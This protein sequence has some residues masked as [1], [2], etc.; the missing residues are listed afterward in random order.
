MNDAFQVMVVTNAI[1][2]IRQ[3][4]KLR[5]PEDVE[6]KIRYV[7]V[8]RSQLSYHLKCTVLIYITI[9]RISLHFQTGEAPEPEAAI[10]DPRGDWSGRRGLGGAAGADGAQ[11][12]QGAHR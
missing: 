8:V 12:D 5:M 1:A 9:N 10:L 4:E 11:G 7:K 2:Y 6:K 3:L